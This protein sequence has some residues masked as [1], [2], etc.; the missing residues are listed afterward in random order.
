MK[1]MKKFM[2]GAATFCCMMITGVALTACGSDDSGGNDN[3]PSALKGVIMEVKFLEPEDVLDVCDATISL[4][5]GAEEAITSPNWTKRVTYNGLPAHFSIDMKM[6]KKD[7]K[8]WDNEKIYSV[9]ILPVSY[10]L[11]V[12]NA[13]G[14]TAIVVPHYVST[15]QNYKGV[16]QMDIAFKKFKEYS[17]NITLQKDGTV[18]YE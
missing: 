10:S 1:M 7:G 8:D 14:D 16:Q 2:M 6:T 18:G 5:D 11:S 13:K 4:N 9:Y 12:F 15:P 17:N 3:N